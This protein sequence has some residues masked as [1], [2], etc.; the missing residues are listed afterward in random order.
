VSDSLHRIGL[1]VPSSN[2]T[3]ETE[4]PELFRWRSAATR[5]RFTWHSARV[6][7]AR[8]TP[9]ELNRM[10]EVSDLAAVSL[11]DSPV[12]VIAYACLVAV[13][14]RGAGAAA[15]VERRLDA[16]LS[17]APRRP[18]VVSS[19]G[20]LVDALRAVGASRVALITPY[21][22]PLAEQVADTVRGEGFDVT[23]LVAF[24]VA[25]N[26]AV[27]RLDPHELPPIAR[28]IDTRTV[29]ALVLSACVQMPSL[30]VVQQV[31]DELGVPVVTAAT[32]TARSILLAL[33]LDP[34]V[35]G[36]GAA[37]A[38]REALTAFARQP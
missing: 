9:E 28:R 16:A 25:D 12:D 26:V 7:M 20:A 29:D 36:A 22:R 13:M 32:A 34:F 30:S 11:A 17:S 3:M 21:L 2:T 24:E 5:E 1:I 37:L 4:L 35:P 8:V 15:E 31:E 27:G 6:P 38:G 33:G 23:D 19:A 10:V 14:C 18:P